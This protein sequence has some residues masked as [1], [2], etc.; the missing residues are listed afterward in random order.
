MSSTSDIEH[1]STRALKPCPAYKDVGTEWFGKVPA[2]LALMA[3]EE[4]GWLGHVMGQG[5]SE[6]C[7]TASIG[8]PQPARSLRRGTILAR[9]RLYI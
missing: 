9:I 6:D 4:R 5:P 2:P 3:A 8:C 1:Q 7:S